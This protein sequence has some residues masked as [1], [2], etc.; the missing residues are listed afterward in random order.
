MGFDTLPWEHREPDATGVRL[1]SPV[2]LLS[3]KSAAKHQFKNFRQL[4]ECMSNIGHR[5][6]LR[7]AHERLPFIR[8]RW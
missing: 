4:W 2:L 1:R 7:T 5:L 3:V 8:Q 6:P